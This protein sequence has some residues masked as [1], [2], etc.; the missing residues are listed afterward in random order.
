[1][2]TTEQINDLHR[3]YWSDHWP[4]RKI[5]RHL[6]M[7]WDTIKKYLDMPAQTPAG[8]PRSSILDPYKATIAELLEKDPSASAAHGLHQPL[9][10]DQTRLAVGIRD[11]ET[12]TRDIWIFDL[13]RG[14]K[15]R[16]T[17]DE[18]DDFNPVWSPD[19]TRIA[20][21]SKRKGNRD[22]YIK[23]AGGA[24]EEQ[25]LLISNVDK[26][27]ESWSSD[28]RYLSYQH[29]APGNSDIHLLPMDTPNR[30]PVPFRATRFAEQ[31]SRFSPDGRLIAYGSFESDRCEVFIQTLAAD[32]GRWQ[33]ST[34]GGNEPDWR[35]DGKELYYVSPDDFLTAVEIQRTGDTV[36]AGTPKNLFPVTRITNRRNRYVVSA[37]GQRFL[38]VTAPPEKTPEPLTVVLN[39]PA[40]LNQK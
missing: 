7:G 25:P 20:Y 8:R 30:Q 6:H 22:L 10:P 37:D 9:S 14:G 15:T 31:N 5:E 35:A 17:F 16:L 33:I 11:P 36:R 4:I 32:G 18:G 29:Q 40:L 27:V 13:R 19:G 2:L 1:M 24:G 26:P 34:E 38:A 23:N 12:D 3:L 28:G 39:W 21:S